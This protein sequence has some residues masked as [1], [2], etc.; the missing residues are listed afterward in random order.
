MTRFKGT[1]VK[2]YWR[3]FDDLAQTPGFRETLR[4]EFPAG[5]EEYEVS[6]VNRRAFIGLMGASMGLA[7]IGAAGCVRKPTQYILPYNERPEDLIPGE[8]R[9]YASA[10]QVG[11]SVVGVLV[12]SQDGRPSKI[13]GNPTHPLSRGTSGALAQAAVLSVYDPDRS[14]S[15]RR[16]GE[17]APLDEVLAELSAL[18][19]AATPTQGRG[20][21]V[22]VE[23]R[24]SPTFVSMLAEL[25]TALPQARIFV[26]DL[27]ATNNQLAGLA[28]AGVTGATVTYELRNARVMLALDSDFLG[29][30]H[31][32]IYHAREFAMGRTVEAES[33]TMNRLYA[34]EPVF[35]ITGATADNRL[36][37][38]ASRVGEF[39]KALAA[40]LAAQ[41]VALPQELRTLTGASTGE[42]FDRW[43]AAVG[44]DLLANRGH[45]AV[46]VG[47]R[48]PAWV[49]ALGFALNEALGGF[50][51]IV[52]IRE[53]AAVPQGGGLS[54][55]VAAAGEIETL[56]IFNANPAYTAP[57][58]LDVRAAL[59]Q[60]A[61]VVHVGYHLDETGSAAR[62]HL[63][64]SHELECWGDLRAAD[65]TASIAQPLI[66][67]L[68]DSVSEIEVLACL[69]PE[70][71]ASTGLDAADGE[72]LSGY[73]QVR[74]FWRNRA[75]QEALL[76]D[77]AWRAWVHEGVVSEATSPSRRG[78]LTFTGVAAAASSAIAVAPT[79]DALEIVW[80]LD[81]KLLDGR[82]ANNAW[83]QE[84]PESMTKL[85]WDN[86]AL[87]GPQTARALGIP[88][89]T[90][91][92]SVDRVSRSFGL[93]FDDNPNAADIPA[94]THGQLNA[95]V[96][97]LT[98]NGRELTLPAFV[99]PGVAENVIG[100]PLGYGRVA[101]TLHVAM[102][103]GQSVGFD[104]Y[105]VLDSSKGWFAGG[106]TI[107][108]TGSTY[109]LA[110]TQDHGSIEGR[111]L[112]AD[113]SLEEYRARPDFVQDLELLPA[114]KLRS[115]W[116]EPH[117]RSGQQWGMSIDL[118]T[119]IGCNACTIAC[120]AENNI[121]VVGKER[122]LQGREMS[123]IR[124]DRYY[125]GDAENPEAIMQ[126]LACMHCENAPCE[127][128]CPVAA[129][130]H[131]P[132]GTNDMVYNRCIGTRY[133][134]NNCPFK[135][136]RFN[137][138]NFNRENDEQNPLLRLQRNANV[139]VR[140]R[141]VMEKCSYCTQRLN[142]AKIH[143]KVAGHAVV[144]D[145][146]VIPAC[147]QACP[148]GAIVFGDVNDP[149]S[150][151][152]QAKRRNRDFALLSWLN[153]HPRTTYLAR[154]RNPNPAL[155]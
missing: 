135:V 114:E 119:C 20:L 112:V 85:C 132:E 87:I 146:A 57:G 65:G 123:W 131:G 88:F 37:I 11:P 2:R 145:G 64:R 149:N 105:P 50:E 137:F 118:T 154:I 155:T 72:P 6:G 126:P 106:A 138:F 44:D 3:S 52:R 93:E 54:E 108:A 4:R 89:D 97:R 100:L 42:K 121:P 38:P 49:H 139:T 12:A 110:T 53:N 148:T 78:P 136:R 117:P 76:F 152:S 70:A 150:R 13:E 62:L 45:A 86:A 18:A 14:Q 129:T 101:P 46:L 81:T 104:T 147:G 79:R 1:S 143:A 82:F 35:S 21:A 111:P 59:G 125:S 102:H 124:L 84:L 23:D 47:E 63:P 122:V 153:I 74:R 7:G 58:D 134:A 5:A 67:P 51:N 15:A 142:Q 120:Q 94:V 92:D 9:Y 16:G 99:T 141:G 10:L 25:S 43:V 103:E 80:G 130:V 55:F 30:G 26:H 41:G 90:T 109:V 33:D 19:A 127:Q 144:A 24:R 48:Q 22:L 83:L 40:Y 113:A 128:V 68:Y 151:V 34:V 36:Q 66:D 32:N 107:A 8:A 96:I 77:R 29:T 69:L 17:E 56:V 61:N 31:D 91:S 28:M 133:C 71:V 75:P 39:A 60:I 73:A 95:P 116:D 140:F 98:V 115:L 27:A